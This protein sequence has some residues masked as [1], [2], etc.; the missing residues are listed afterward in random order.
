MRELLHEDE[1]NVKDDIRRFAKSNELARAV[2]VRQ[3][4]GGFKV[5]VTRACLLKKQDELSSVA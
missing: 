5:L 3:D 4:Q 1:A 2:F